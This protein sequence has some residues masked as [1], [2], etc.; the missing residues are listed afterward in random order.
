M[1]LFWYKVIPKMYTLYIYNLKYLY[2][3][4]IQHKYIQYHT[5][6]ILKGIASVK[7]QVLSTKIR[8]ND[9]QLSNH[10]TFL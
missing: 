3:Y 1:S 9:M 6:S 10:L 8:S 2:T 4:L 7:K 5:K